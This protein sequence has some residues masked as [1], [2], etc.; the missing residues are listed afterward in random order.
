[1]QQIVQV[2][3]NCQVCAK[4]TKPGKG[5]LIS[6]L[7]S[8]YPWQVVGTDVFEL[9]KNDYLL[10]VDYFSRYPEVVKV[11]STTSASIIA[12]LKSIFARH[13]IPEIIS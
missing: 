8:K 12:V 1:M 3:Q 13:G 6:T 11:T 9:N 5:P 4:E 7:L 10:V 2:V